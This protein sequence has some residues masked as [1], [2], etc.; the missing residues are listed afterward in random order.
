MISHVINY[1]TCRQ[2][3]YEAL[4]SAPSLALSLPLHKI[5]WVTVIEEVIRKQLN[6]VLQRS[7]PDTP[8]YRL[9]TSQGASCQSGCQEE[10]HHQQEQKGIAPDDPKRIDF[11]SEKWCI[12]Q[13][14]CPVRRQG[15]EARP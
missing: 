7:K 13:L 14:S 4:P 1:V 3:T 12:Q 11:Q 2:T 15:C 5:P 10:G 8:N 6:P 9:I